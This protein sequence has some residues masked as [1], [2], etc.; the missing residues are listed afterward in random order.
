MEAEKTLKEKVFDVCDALAN[1]GEKITRDKVR[2]CTKGSDRD[3]SKYIAE[4]KASKETAITVAGTSL[5]SQ[6]QQESAAISSETVPNPVPIQPVISQA[7]IYQVKLNA[8]E[9]VKSL[10]IAE[11]QIARAMQEN[12][13]LLPEEIKQEIAEAEMAAISTPLSHRSYYD[14]N[15]LTQAV[16]ASL[17]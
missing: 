14:P 2:E 7:D 16:I 4:W 17:L 10:R 8:A 1:S 13:N 12:P 5:I 9:R 11:I 15:T 3:I 6:Q